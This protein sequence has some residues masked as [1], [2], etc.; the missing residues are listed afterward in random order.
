M[1][2]F[3]FG[4]HICPLNRYGENII[5][6]RRRGEGIRVKDPTK[7]RTNRLTLNHTTLAA[8]EEAQKAK[9]WLDIGAAHGSAVSF[10]AFLAGE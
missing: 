4:L 7:I 2:N 3:F 9:R 6:R 10:R 1:V 8:L 5:E